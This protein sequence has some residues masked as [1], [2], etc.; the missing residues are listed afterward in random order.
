METLTKTG[1]VPYYLQLK[2]ILHRSIKKGELKPGQLLPPERELCK[3]HQVSRITIRKALD[4]LMQEGFIFREQGR[5][6]FVSKPPLEQPTQIISFTEQM[7]SRGLSPSTRVLETG[8]LPVSKEIGEY[9][10]LSPNEEV[11]FVKRLRL[12]DN[13]PVALESSYLPYRFY[14][15]ILSENLTGSLTKIT[16]QKYHLRLKR[17]AQVVKAEPVF[18]EVAKIL[19]VEPGTPALYIQRIAF[20]ADNRPAEFLKAYYRGDRYE[21]TMELKGR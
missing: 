7:E 8:I 2:E 13:E 17:A 20:L 19:E 4:L 11:V 3:R 18:D 16:E 12:A 5:G 21:L 1:F 10:A 9:L 15:Q 14:P 6:T